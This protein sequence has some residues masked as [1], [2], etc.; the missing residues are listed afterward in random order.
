MHAEAWEYFL[1]EKSSAV[2]LFA[3]LSLVYRQHVE[4]TLILRDGRNFMHGTFSI[5][6][7]LTLSFFLQSCSRD[8]IRLIPQK[9]PG[10]TPVSS[11][12]TT[13]EITL[14]TFNRL[15][16][17]KAGGFTRGGINGAYY[18]NPSFAGNPLFNRSDVR[19]DFPEGT[20]SWGGTVDPKHA[21]LP[22]TGFSVRWTGQLIPNTTEKFTFLVSVIGKATASIRPAGTENFETI[23]DLKSSGTLTGTYSL[24]KGQ[25]YDV[26]IEYTA[27]APT[28]GITLA[29]TSPTFAYEIVEPLRQ[30][31]LNMY[32]PVSYDDHEPLLADAV[33]SARPYFHDGSQN[34]VPADEDGWPRTDAWLVLWEGIGATGLMEGTFSVSFKG[35]ATIDY[36]ANMNLTY[37]AATN[38]TSGIWV[39]SAH[40]SIQN[41]LI[42]FVNTRRTPTSPLNSGITDL[43]MMRPQS[44]GSTTPNP[45]TT[46]FYQPL[47]D[48]IQPFSTLRMMIGTNY[49][50]STNWSDRTKPSYYTQYGPKVAGETGDEG[51][52]QSWEYQIMLANASGKDLYI[53]IPELATG[54][55][56][57]DTTSYIYQL[58]KLL[59]DGGTD[60]HGVTYPGLN[61]NLKLYV[62]YSNEVWNTA[63][64]QFI[65]NFNAAKASITA[66]NEEGKMLTYDGNTDLN[67][68]WNRRHALRTVQTSTIF[69]A[70]F[71]DAAMGTRVRLL[72]E[73]QYANDGWPATAQTQLG[74]I[75]DYFNNSDGQT[76]VSNPKPVS[77][78]LWGAGGANYYTGTVSNPATVAQVF[79][80][81][82]LNLFWSQAVDCSGIFAA[83]Y[84][85]TLNTETSWANRYGL[86]E[87]AYEGGWALGTDGG[88]S[89]VQNSAKFNSPPQGPCVS[90]TNRD[91]TQASQN[92][93][94]YL[95]DR[96]GGG[97]TV[98]GTYTQWNTLVNANTSPIRLSVIESTETARFATTNA[99]PLPATLTPSGKHID[100]GNSSGT[101]SKFGWISWNTLVATPTAF[102]ITVQL[103]SPGSL[104][105]LSDG[106]VVAEGDA[107]A[108]KDVVLNLTAGLHSL[109]VQAKDP[110]IKIN[111]IEVK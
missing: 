15:K 47:L 20:R 88:G 46:L 45:E 42:H 24:T 104:R 22:V 57:S 100:Y 35:Q 108:L 49:N 98:L 76:H 85:S 40:G 63:F 17:G 26:K 86:E 3:K 10:A 62:E 59:K 68:G 103:G 109:V 12:S 48:A 18:A 13:D 93:F 21:S 110:A 55:S 23:I 33:K 43:K 54:T 107:A 99:T 16:L 19:L 111:S 60:S 96:S 36:P 64:T 78:Y 73:F 97:L 94:F 89:S 11:A 90:G 6:F 39:N 74:F 66:M 7:F 31:G 28:T 56:P 92:Q 29:W 5:L 2:S 8:S 67:V 79:G 91:C 32:R 65:Q 82:I 69:R 41:F 102:H 44:I 95:F 87:V 105:L 71:G 83:N 4:S 50:V 1:E 38:R 9:G 106:I 81:C 72:D 58:A 25:K 101:L 37:D 30:V 34:P 51:H 52:G 80:S 61:P 53:T 77:Y 84:S 27:N 75:D 70:V 14:P